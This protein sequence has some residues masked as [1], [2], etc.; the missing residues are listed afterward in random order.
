MS[1]WMTGCA[2]TSFRGSAQRHG[3]LRALGHA[4]GYGGDDSQRHHTFAD[5]YTLKM[6]SPKK[7]SGRAPR[8]LGET[9]IDF[10]ARTQKRSRDGRIQRKIL[11]N[12]RVIPSFMPLWRLTPFTP[13]PK[14][15][16]D[17]AALARKYHAPN[18]DSRGGNEKGMMDSLANT[19]TPCS[20]GAHRLLGPDVVAA[21]CIW[22][23][24]RI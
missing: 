12:G 5:M 14:D 8:I 15:A 21:H 2:N 24:T 1:L 23:T 13:A 18:P 17:A 22:W 7:Q 4:P 16:A 10:P 19:A 9:W 11:K 3:R 6:L 20:T